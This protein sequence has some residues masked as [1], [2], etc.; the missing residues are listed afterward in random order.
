MILKNSLTNMSNSKTF[1]VTHVLVREC[2]VTLFDRII[3][4]NQ[5]IVIAHAL[6][7]FDSQK[8]VQMYIHLRTQH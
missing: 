6:Y 3:T 5:F 2:S 7:F 4:K 8:R 1:K